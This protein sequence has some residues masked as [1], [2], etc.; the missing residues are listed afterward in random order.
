MRSLL[1]GLLS[2]VLVASTACADE[3]YSFVNE[4][5]HPELRYD[6]WKEIRLD[7]RA[8]AQF[9]PF[10]SQVTISTLPPGS[11][12]IKYAGLDEIVVD[13]FQ[14]KAK[15]F[16]RDQLRK[17][18]VEGDLSYQSYQARLELIERRSDLR[19][20]WWTRHWF[21][22]FPPEKGGA[23]AAPIYQ[24]IGS[25]HQILSIGRFGIA[26]TGHFQYRKM[27]IMKVDSDNRLIPRN[28]DEQIIE[29]NPTRRNVDIF[30]GQSIKSDNI[31]FKCN[32]VVKVRF[33]KWPTVLEAALKAELEL[34]HRG[35]AYAVLTC[36]VFYDSGNDHEVGVSVSAQLINW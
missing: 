34:R 22:S 9:T 14:K 6:I 10:I 30:F 31:R 24:I 16:C 19:G 28:P 21:E 5:D 15:S 8:P 13:Q 17:Q 11:F 27:N 4:I 29:D 26:N 23:P 33:D 36:A 2:V 18:Y 7:C 3:D 35:Q 25:Q 20:D 32:P 1:I 12:G